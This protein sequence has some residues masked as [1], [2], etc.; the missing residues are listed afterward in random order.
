MAKSQATYSK[1]ENEKKK[2]SDKKNPVLHVLL[3]SKKIFFHQC[4]ITC[5]QCPRKNLVTKN[6][7]K[8]LNIKLYDRG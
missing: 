6:T 2:R 5:Y 7:R 4:V 1:K 8:N 3:P